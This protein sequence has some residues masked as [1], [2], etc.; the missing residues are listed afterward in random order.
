MPAGDV[1]AVFEVG[2][3]RQMYA[4]FQGCDGDKK[5]FSVVVIL[6]WL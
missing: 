3:R 4:A 1:C 5:K 2:Y 6:P